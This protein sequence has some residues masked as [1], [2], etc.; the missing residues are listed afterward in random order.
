MLRQLSESPVV[1]EAL[2]S[3]H[4]PFM[5]TVLILV[6]CMHASDVPASLVT[7]LTSEVGCSLVDVI[8][9]VCEMHALKQ[10]KQCDST[11][12]CLSVSMPE[13]L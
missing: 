11:S 2:W 1:Y 6:S 3:P 10:K 7:M 12:V 9:T 5:W 4:M 8:M 13:S